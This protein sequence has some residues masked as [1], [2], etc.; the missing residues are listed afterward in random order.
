ML[1]LTYIHIFLI[2][3]YP[4]HA[5]CGLGK[6]NCITDAC[7][8]LMCDSAWAVLPSGFVLVHIDLF[9]V[10]LLHN[11]SLLII[12]VRRLI[13][14]FSLIFNFHVWV[15]GLLHFSLLCFC[16]FLDPALA[17]SHWELLLLLFLSVFI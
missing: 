9:M 14:I 5:S 16:Q 10:I 15:R 13:K 17:G 6:Y 1:I 2:F 12:I 7:S 3:L 11:M 4:Y 8:I